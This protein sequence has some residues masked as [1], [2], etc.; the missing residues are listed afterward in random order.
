[1][2]TRILIQRSK[3]HPTWKIL[4]CLAEGILIIEDAQCL[5]SSKHD[6]GNCGLI[7]QSLFH[8]I[9]WESSRCTLSNVRQAVICPLEMNS[10][11]LATLSWNQLRDL[12]VYKEV[13]PIHSV[14][15][16]NSIACVT[17]KCLTTYIN[18]IFSP[19]FFFLTNQ[20]NTAEVWLCVWCGLTTL[21]ASFIHGCL[22]LLLFLCII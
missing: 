2:T 11:C 8:L 9:G 21:L 19:F 10:F 6:F 22:F 7:A 1:M 20:Q 12:T 14:I 16:N 17:I 15:K 5:V 4:Q 3:P 13:W 18:V